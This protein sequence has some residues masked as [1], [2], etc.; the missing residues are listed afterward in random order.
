[1]LLPFLL[2]FLFSERNSTYPGCMTPHTFRHG[3][4]E[5]L[6]RSFPLSETPF[7][8][9]LNEFLGGPHVK[10]HMDTLLKRI[11]YCNSL[12]SEILNALGVH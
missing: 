7:Y 3:V 6:E 1:M 9:C 2:R 11:Q 4:T 8:P 5:A 10:T 12:V